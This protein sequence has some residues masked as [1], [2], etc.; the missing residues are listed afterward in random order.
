MELSQDARQVLDLLQEGA[1]CLDRDGRVV[2]WNGAAIALTGYRPD[3]V[4]GRRCRDD[5]LV[6]V[7]D[8]E[9][10]LC[11]GKCPMQAAMADGTTREGD[12][13]LL[14]ADGSRCFV[15]VRIAPLRGSHDE[16]IGAIQLFQANGPG[17]EAISRLEELERATAID[18]VTGVATRRFIEDSVRARLEDVRRTGARL[19]VLMVDIDEFKLINDRFGH[20]TGDEVLRA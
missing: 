1:Y 17:S 16:I 6:H 2:Y 3:Q 4:L 10:A 15:R 14:R 19:G 5:I 11:D 8:E 18:P 7:A 13:H 9:G 12:V 20:T